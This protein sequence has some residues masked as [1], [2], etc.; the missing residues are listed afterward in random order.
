MPIY[1]YR[2]ESC[3]RRQSFLVPSAREGFAPVCRFCGSK[4][5]TRLISR[6]AVLRSEESRLESLADPGRWGDLDESDPKSMARFMKRMG[7]AVGEDLG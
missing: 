1:E 7:E 5:L 6:V 2:C 3:R 4:R